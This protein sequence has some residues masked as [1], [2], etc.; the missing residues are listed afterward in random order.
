M[1]SKR[2]PL[3]NRQ[4]LKRSK[5]K[6]QQ[7]KPVK[8]RSKLAQLLPMLVK[9]VN[10]RKLRHSK[11]RTMYSKF[12][13]M[14]ALLRIL[15]NKRNRPQRKRNVR[16]KKPPKQ[17]PLRSNKRQLHN[18]QHKVLNNSYQWQA[19]LHQLLRSRR[20]K[21]VNRPMSRQILRKMRLSKRNKPGNL[22]K[23]RS[24]N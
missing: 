14:P 17:V 2:K 12:R 1:P 22:R 9:P 13:L 23:K 3:R 21:Q 11:A 15:I 7:H 10:K 4:G 8:V 20:K 5:R 19:L 16:R 24:S 18:K 6:K